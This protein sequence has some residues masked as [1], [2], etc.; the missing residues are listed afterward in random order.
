MALLSDKNPA[1]RHWGVEKIKEIR[2]IT[3]RPVSE[4]FKDDVR[5]WQKVTLLFS[6]LPE[7]Y[8]DMIGKK[9]S[10]LSLT[11]KDRNYDS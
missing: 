2:Q 6:P 11:K 8:K 4:Y 1:M 7:H 3:D 10:L 9:N 5:T